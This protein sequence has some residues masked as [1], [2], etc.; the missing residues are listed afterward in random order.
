[1]RTGTILALMDGGY[2][3]MTDVLLSDADAMPDVIR[4]LEHQS[5]SSLIA[6]LRKRR[7]QKWLPHITAAFLER[8]DS[9]AQTLGKAVGQYDALTV[10]FLNTT[11]QSRHYPLP[12]LAK[13]KKQ[14]SLRYVLFYYDIMGRQS[15][16]PA[17]EFLASGLV[18]ACYS[19]SKKDCDERKNV[20]F[21]PTPYSVLPEMKEIRPTRDLYFC[22]VDN[23]RGALLRSVGDAGYAAGADVLM[24]V[25][26]CAEGSPELENSPNIKLL[27]AY[28]GY[29]G[30]REVLQRT[31]DAGCLLEI[32]MKGQTAPTLRAYEA[33]AYGRKLL[34]NNPGIREWPLYD[35]ENMRVFERAEEIDWQWVKT[36]ATPR[37]YN[38]ELS[39]RRLIEDMNRRLYS[40]RK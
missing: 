2:Q 18:D 36:P 34:T 33:A 30:Y 23:G 6:L 3:E 15:C 21:W 8:D 20:I 32:T 9:L 27:D 22:G 11:L 31:L 29:R 19:F 26:A 40:D 1:M 16:V 4:S 38:G 17:N 7:V 13:W 12:L 14:Y 24:E 5:A 10:F 35:P 28:K 39:P 25:V 37:P